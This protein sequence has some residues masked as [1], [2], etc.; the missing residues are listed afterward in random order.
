MKGKVILI[1][2]PLRVHIYRD[3][4]NMIGIVAVRAN[5]HNK[6]LSREQNYAQLDV[7]KSKRALA[8]IPTIF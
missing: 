1:I 2:R 8:R 4:Q 3:N 7:V 5:I 6:L